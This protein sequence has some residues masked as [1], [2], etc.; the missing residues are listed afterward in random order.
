MIVSSADEPG[1]QVKSAVGIKN[2]SKSHVAFKVSI[3]TV[4]TNPRFSFFCVFPFKHIMFYY[5]WQLVITSWTTWHSILHTVLHWI[6]VSEAFLLAIWYYAYPPIESS[7]CLLFPCW[8]FSSKRL[9]QRVVT[10]V[11]Q[12]EYLLLVKVLLQLV[13]HCSWYI[14]LPP[15][16]PFHLSSLALPFAIYIMPASIDFSV[17]HLKL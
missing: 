11:L 8:F 16:S 6:T 4:S 12:V 3:V 10:C 13:I 2:T 15:P 9:H 17:Y 5:A 1:K 7:K 14:S